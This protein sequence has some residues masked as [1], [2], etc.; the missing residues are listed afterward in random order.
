MKRK[1]NPYISSMVQNYRDEAKA[2]G[3]DTSKLTNEQ[4]FDLI[5]ECTGFASNNESME[6]F[7]QLLKD[8]L[9]TLS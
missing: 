5:E 8:K 1:Y 9:A 2:V 6:Y 4:I 7:M 3:L